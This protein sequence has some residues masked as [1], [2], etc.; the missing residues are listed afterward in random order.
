MEASGFD[1]KNVTTSVGAGYNV[2][3]NQEITKPN[4]SYPTPGPS[5]M[6]MSQQ[7]NLEAYRA[8]LIKLSETVNKAGGAG[9]GT[10]RPLPQ[11]DLIPSDDNLEESDE[12]LGMKMLL[13][14][15]IFSENHF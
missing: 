3:K 2:S 12:E 10:K 4:S 11:D 13:Y 1:K 8:E 7:L 15:Y 5:M 9:A 14:K 6:T